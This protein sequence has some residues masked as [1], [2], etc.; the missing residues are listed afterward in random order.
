MLPTFQKF[1]ASIFRLLP[2]NAQ[3]AIMGLFSTS[4]F[5]NFFLKHYLL[6]LSGHRYIFTQKYAVQ[7]CHVNIH[8]R[9]TTIKL[10]FNAYGYLQSYA[11]ISS[12]SYSSVGLN[13]CNLPSEHSNRISSSVAYS[14]S[15]CSSCHIYICRTYI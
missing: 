14:K 9:A 7:N 11:Y 8:V 15:K 2:F 1:E 5:F 12:F 6:L 10:T 13:L 4:R 3:R